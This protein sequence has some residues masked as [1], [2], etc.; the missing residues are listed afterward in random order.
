[1]GKVLRKRLLELQEKY[2]QIG[3]V[4][5]LGLMQAVDFVKDRKT[6]EP[7]TKL[8]DRI[9]YTAFQNGL[10]TLSTGL[11]AIRLIPPLI[12]NE[13]QINMGVEALEKG[14]KAAL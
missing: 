3:D 8:R 11:S 4:R 9:E 7:D 12:V 5:G 6:R 10:L 14:I 1:M 13:S 2:H